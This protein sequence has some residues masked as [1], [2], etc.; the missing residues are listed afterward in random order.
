M[1][2][3]VGPVVLNLQLWFIGQTQRLYWK[4]SLDIWTKLK[5][6]WTFCCSLGNWIL[7]PNILCFTQ[8]VSVRRRELDCIRNI[9]TAFQ[10]FFMKSPGSCMSKEGELIEDISSESN[11]CY[12]CMHEQEWFINPHAQ[13]NPRMLSP[14]RQTV[15]VLRYGL[16]VHILHLGC[17]LW[18]QVLSYIILFLNKCLMGK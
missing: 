18:K 5:V 3:R 1:F 12:L 8:H 17:I 15:Y 2:C 14:C 9:L 6:W 16:Q 13:Q 7:V 10:L 11:A 4:G